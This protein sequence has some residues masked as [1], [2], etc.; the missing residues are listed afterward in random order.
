M[1]IRFTHECQFVIYV[2]YFV[3]EGKVIGKSFPHVINLLVAAHYY[4]PTIDERYL[5]GGPAV[6]W[7]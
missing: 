7:M 6:L 1:N 4:H 5:E 2:P 3:H